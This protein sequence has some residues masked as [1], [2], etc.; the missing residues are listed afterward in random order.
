[1]T[2]LKQ[3]SRNPESAMSDEASQHIDRAASSVRRWGVLL[4]ISAVLM[5]LYAVM[6]P[7]QLDW[8]LGA[9][10]VVT[11]AAGGMLLPA[12]VGLRRRKNWARKSAFAGCVLTGFFILWQIVITVLA[13]VQYAGSEENRHEQ[14]AE[15]T[16]GM[17]SESDVNLLEQMESRFVIAAGIAVVLVSVVLLW[18]LV[19]VI[20]V[21]RYLHSSATREVFRTHPVQETSP[22]DPGPV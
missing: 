13:A 22:G 5:G 6:L 10:L 3:N 11:A 19:K 7:E 16:G 15:L 20:V 12:N 9:M 17:L 1:M 8:E 18:W 2:D 4:V 14:L 21:A